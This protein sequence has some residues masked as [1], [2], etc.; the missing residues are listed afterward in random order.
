MTQT[1]NIRDIQHFMYCPRR[2]ALLSINGDW[3][4]NAFVVK[5]N[6][7]HEHVHD[8]SHC[9]S[10]KTKTVRSA[11]SIYN[12]LPEYD[13]F[14][15]TDCVEFIK[16]GAGVEIQELKGKYKVRLVEYKPRAPKDCDFHESDAI[17]VFAQKLCADFVW[18]CKSEAYIYYS[19]IKK[20]VHLPFE[21]EY[22]RYDA[23]IKDILVQ[24]RA[25]VEEGKI[26]KRKRG[27]KCSGCSIKDICFPKES[28]YNV[29]MVIMS[30]KG[31]D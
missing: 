20:R 6:L 21:T 14:G 8:G 23:L 2:F 27:Q 31:A 30:Q 7:I 26:P 22:E 25:L 9:F 19:D 15:M 4:E 13:I 29:R 24:M 3:N 5:A 11:V 28:E 10:D 18:N 16:D 1:I 17:Q 12:D